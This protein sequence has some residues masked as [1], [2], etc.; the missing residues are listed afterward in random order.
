MRSPTLSTLLLRTRR[1]VLAVAAPIVVASPSALAQNATAI[2]RGFTTPPDAAKPRVWWHWMN[3]NVTKEGITADLEWM[4]RVG[5]GGMQMFD[6]SLG[7]PQFTEK[8][9]VWMT[10]EWKDAFRH[11]GIE[12]NRLGLEMTIAASGGWSETGGPWV[13]PEQAMKKVVWSDTTVS[14]PAHFTGA[15]PKPPSNNGPFQNVPMAPSFDFAEATTL[16]GAKPS[17]PRAPAPPDPTFY[18]DTKVIAVRL[19]DD[20]PSMRERRPRVTSNASTVNLT[21]LTDGDLRTAVTIPYADD[22]KRAW[23]QFEFAEPFRA[24]A[25]T[26][27]APPGAPFF[28]RPIPNGEL[29]SSQDGTQWTTL[30]ALPGDGHPLGNFMVRTYAF[31]A[32][33]ARYYRVLLS[34]PAR[35]DSEDP[36]GSE[37]QRTRVTITE[38][39]LSAEPRVNR[40]EEKAQF[41]NI[42]EYGASIAT[43]STPDA[44]ASRDVIDLTARMRRDGTLD[45]EV[46]AGRW[47]VLRMGYSLTGKKNHPATV[48]AT[49]FEVDK[50]SRQHVTAYARH[51][52]DLIGGAMGRE[53]GRSL[54]YFVMDSWE[55]GLETW[56]DDL[57]DQFRTRRGYDATRYL[58]V[59]TG[60]VVGSADTSDRFLWDYRRTLADLLAEN[61]YSAAN[62]YLRTRGV[63]IYAEA[64]GAGLQTTGDGLLDKGQ[65][66]VPMGEFW[67]PAPGVPDRPDHPA[68]LREAASAAHIYGKPIAAAESFT[69]CNAASYWSPP[70]Y[71]KQFADRAMSLG[72][73][74]FVIHTSDHQ[75]FVDAKHR[76]GITLGPCGI[77][78]TRN[79]TWAE[80]SAAFN[81]YLA[82]GSYMLQ[83]GVFVADLAYFYGEGAPVA[84]PFW[85]TVRPA[86][87]A[88]YAYDFVNAD[89]LMTRASAKE[90][91]LALAGG[92]SYRVL[93]LPEDVSRLTLPMLRKLRDLVASGV[94]I[95]APKPGTPPS[96]SGGANGDAEARA[97]ADAVWGN[98][99]GRGVTEH[100]YGR[101]KVYW[102]R[103]VASVLAANGTAEDVRF[104]MPNTDSALVWI[105]RR[106]AGADIYFV[107]NQRDRAVD[108]GASFRIAGKAPELWH[109]D[110]GEREPAPYRIEDGRT[111]VPLRLDAYGSV[112][113]VFRDAASTPSRAQPVETRSTLT[114]IAGPWQGTFPPDLGAPG[115]ARFDSLTAWNSSSD[116][117]IKYFSGTATYAKEFEV[118]PDWLRPDA[119]VV[120]DLGAVKEIAEVTVNGTAVG[121]VLW[122]APYSVDATRALHAGTNRLEVK[123]TN[124][125]VNRIVG[126][127]QPNVTARYTFL[128]FPQYSKS[129]PL[130][131]SGLL[132]PVRLELVSR[133]SVTGAR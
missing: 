111:T 72:I 130:L 63:G 24:Q 78:Y 94:V 86:P 103:P 74:R 3:G 43:P 26:F 53:L 60:R 105:H 84:V 7:V 34:N 69:T 97:I 126:D 6:G 70:S 12:A 127:A 88:G 101:G 122:K 44:I 99:D 76:P 79:N 66:D 31:P 100:A 95:V 40:W 104:T 2:E 90:G 10:P 108:V 77:H 13:T 49:G 132:G 82:R 123:V 114:T 109:L 1:V 56:T 5:I 131:Q 11:A 115:R 110:T 46:P 52:A 22:D 83:Q 89:V 106:S 39:A 107:A 37:P 9:L 112:F 58:P 54:R 62:A 96:L 125:W 8:R 59:L 47:T 68:D 71:L 87:P 98:I 61:H 38:L 119:R 15:L 36:F 133:T 45:W 55:A 23:V 73:N 32:T 129:A 19:R 124:L 25:F 116:D 16:P 93:V 102:G 91:R 41:G 51:Y 92:M 48:E 35:Q 75:P 33:T 27:A 4:K 57:L 113:V 30:V 121:G 14:G 64:I 80:Q 65:V 50:L 118:S 81:A 17:A 20:E 42:V 18:A 29:Q 120:L 28:A 21:A 85:K 117:G 128:G 67:T